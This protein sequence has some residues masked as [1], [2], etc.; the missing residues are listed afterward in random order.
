MTVS[1]FDPEEHVVHRLLERWHVGDDTPPIGV[2]PDVHQLDRLTADR[3]QLDER[4]TGHRFR[5]LQRHLLR[6]L[7]QM[8]AGGRMALHEERVSQRRPRD[9]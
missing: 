1:A 2:G 3:R 4:F 5:E 8:L 6:S 9:Q 7:G